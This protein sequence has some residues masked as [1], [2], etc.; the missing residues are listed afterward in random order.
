MLNPIILVPM[1]VF[2]R[3]KK[4]LP[5][6]H[7]YEDPSSKTLNLPEIV[8][9]LHEKLG[10]IRVDTRK[11]LI[12]TSS[13]NEA[14]VLA[15]RIAEIKIRDPTSRWA[16]SEPFPA[17]IEFEWKL[18]LNPTKRLTGILYDGAQLQLIAL[19]LLPRDELTLDN[20][21]VVFTN[22]LFGTYEPDGRY[23]AHVSIY[24]FPSLISTTGI[25]EAPAK[26]KEFYELRQRYLA[27]G[28][29]VALERLKERFRE[30]FIDH[31]DPR[32]TEVFKGYVMQAV[33]YH[34]GLDLFCADKRCRLYNARWQEEVIEAQLSEPEFCER[35]AALLEELRTSTR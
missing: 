24:G 22:R 18:L 26:P 10:E 32:L 30:R 33:F 20:L 2:E 4:S 13:R 31:D 6:I 19:E 29:Q 14:E 3:E 11:P 9:Y 17:E 21:H 34:L 5:T 12:A 23:H 28:N 15:R 1:G 27:L 7:L 8:R 16:R 35:H 25:V